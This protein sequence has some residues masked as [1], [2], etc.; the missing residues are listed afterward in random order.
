MGNSRDSLFLPPIPASW[1]SVLGQEVA[2]PYFKQLEG[3]LAEERR[4]RAVYP[5]ADETFAALEMTPCERVSVL[6]LGQDP[7]PNPGQA[8]GL[9][10][11]VRP[12]VK[13]PASL[14][15]IFKEMHDDLGL[16]IPQSGSLIPWA[17]Q[18]VLLLNTVL[19]VRAGE[20]LSHRGKG[21]EIFTDAV[22]RGVSEKT[23]PVVFV[24]WGGQAQKKAS[25]IDTSRHRLVTAAHPSPLSAH[26]GFLG[27]K[28]FS[29]IN[30]ALHDLHRP[31]ID[32]RLEEAAG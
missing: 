29:R 4:T 6:L 18:G 32:W 1:Q 15:N 3:F 7:Y 17:R 8:H 10:F 9:C 28:P 12:G 19:T 24:L 21:W 2:K 20:A 11:S 25:L 5:P 22:I 16:P 23:D 26:N 27:S 30:A 31:A 13:F 14:R